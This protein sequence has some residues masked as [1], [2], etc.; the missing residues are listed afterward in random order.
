LHKTIVEPTATLKK[1][2]TDEDNDTST[3]A[4][5]STDLNKGTKDQQDPL[6]HKDVYEL[7]LGH[8]SESHYVSLRPMNWREELFEG[9][10]PLII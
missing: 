4:D 1:S 10:L 7:Y 9:N 2:S 5:K 6:L 3:T 8:I